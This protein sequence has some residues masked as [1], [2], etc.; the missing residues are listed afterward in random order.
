M[1]FGT[2]LKLLIAATSIY[3]QV[4]ADNLV[5]MPDTPEAL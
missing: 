3:R 1:Q 2:T 5:R 4:S